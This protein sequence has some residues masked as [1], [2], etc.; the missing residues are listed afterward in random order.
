M[1]TDCVLTGCSY[2]RYVATC[3]LITRGMFPCEKNKIELLECS[4]ATDWLLEID[5]TYLPSLLYSLGWRI[6]LTSCWAAS[7]IR[8]DQISFNP[9]RW[10]WTGTEACQTHIT[11]LY[12]FSS[13]Q[14]H[15]DHHHLL[16]L[17]KFLLLYS[18][19]TSELS[20]KIN[21]FKFVPIVSQI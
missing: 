11:L 7:R 9:S 8:S 19:F 14:M 10:T 13:S 18:S 5:P 15:T 21:R 6:A 3:L 16:Y 2:M 17:N 20:K 4:E 1:T 12:F